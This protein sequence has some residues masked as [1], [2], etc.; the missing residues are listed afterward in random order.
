MSPLLWRGDLAGLDGN[1][2]MFVRD[3]GPAAN[4]RMLAAVPQRR[5]WLLVPASPDAPPALL[6]Y[7]QSMSTL[8]GPAGE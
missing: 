2:I 7:A 1:N 4:A 8:W 3:L 6:P 5:P